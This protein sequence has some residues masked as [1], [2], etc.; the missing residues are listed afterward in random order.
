MNLKFADTPKLTKEAEGECEIM[1][2]KNSK[3]TAGEYIQQLENKIKTLEDALLQT[4]SDGNKL[5][6]CVEM[7]EKNNA[8]NDGNNITQGPNSN[9]QTLHENKLNVEHHNDTENATSASEEN[10]MCTASEEK[11]EVVDLRCNCVL[12]E[13]PKCD[14]DS[15]D[16]AFSYVH[17][18]V[19]EMNAQIADNSIIHIEMDYPYL[20]VYFRDEDSKIEFLKNRFIYEYNPNTEH[21]LRILDYSNCGIVDIEN[22][23]SSD[24][25]LETAF[26]NVLELAKKMGVTNFRN[27][28]DHIDV[29]STKPNFLTYS[30]RFN[31][32]NKKYVFLQNKDILKESPETKSLHFT[33]V[34]GHTS[35]YFKVNNLSM[36]A[37]C[38]NVIGVAGL[39]GLS[40]SSDNFKRIY[41]LNANAFTDNVA[42][43]HNSFVVEFFNSDIKDE[44]LEKASELNQFDNSWSSY[45][46]IS[47]IETEG[48]FV[49]IKYTIWTYIF[50]AISF[51]GLAM[52]LGYSFAPNQTDR[53]IQLSKFIWKTSLDF[54]QDM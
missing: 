18:L 19:N 48:N 43:V 25:N 38:A 49:S 4:K 8:S 12:I 36:A 32:Q 5:T 45:I 31:R 10:R 47:D 3:N 29:Y 16:E 51:I 17:E 22:Y 21:Y 50:T 6:D 9:Q 13:E 40:L 34:G 15:L 27:F 53:F 42:R 11:Q 39:M 26:V 28:I 30:V 35:S 54:V 52:Q 2:L 24:L 33:D 20:Y 41:V 46:E 1:E 7:I 37:A 23:Q 44:F 14:T